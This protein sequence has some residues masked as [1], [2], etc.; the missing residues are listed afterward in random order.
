MAELVH[1]HT[2]GGVATITLD[3]QHNRNALSAQLMAELTTRLGVAQE[4]DAVRVIVLS[5][6]GR[7]FC[8]G[9]DLSEAR[10]ARPEVWASTPSRRFCSRSGTARS[11]SSPGSAARLGPAVWG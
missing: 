4:D 11:R 8:S 9:M 10:G 2:A 1:A 7:V 5:H 6:Q 3:S